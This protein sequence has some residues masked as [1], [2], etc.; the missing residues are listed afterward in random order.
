MD[1]IGDSLKSVAFG[2]RQLHLR[3]GLRHYMAPA[4]GT[5]ASGVESKNGRTSIPSVMIWIMPNM[6]ATN[7]TPQMNP[8]G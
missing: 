5:S 3:N 7:I 1:A 6:A 8:A 4:R 2:K